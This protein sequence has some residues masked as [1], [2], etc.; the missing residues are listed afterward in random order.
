M[1]KLI[2]LAPSDYDRPRVVADI[3]KGIMTQ[4]KDLRDP[5][6]IRGWSV[7]GEAAFRDEQGEV[8]GQIVLGDFLIPDDVFQKWDGWTPVAT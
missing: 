7:N 3:G 5:L 4:P 8:L 1:K 2:V 6:T